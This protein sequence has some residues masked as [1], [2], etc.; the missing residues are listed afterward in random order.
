M[1]EMDDK[2]HDN[3]PIICKWGIYSIFEIKSIVKNTWN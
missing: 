2:A 1:K 3:T